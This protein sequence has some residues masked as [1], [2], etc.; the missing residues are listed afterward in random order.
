MDDD[1]TRPPQTRKR[2]QRRSFSAGLVGLLVTIGSLAAACGSA[3]K[4]PGAASAAS[5]ST[6]TTAAPSGSSGSSSSAQSSQA[7]ELRLAQCMRA[8]GVPHFPDPPSNGAFLNALGASGV[9]PNSPI[10]QSALQACKKYN[11]DENLTPSESAAQNAKG[12]EISQ[13]MRSHGVPTFPDPSTG[14][15]GE[16]V[17]NLRGTGIDPGSPTYQAASQACQKIVPGGK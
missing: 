5:T 15:L 7:E 11:P 9:N 1:S 4:D 14:P 3:S 8:N 6:S 17:M 16:Q 12:V 2:R 10:F 13:C